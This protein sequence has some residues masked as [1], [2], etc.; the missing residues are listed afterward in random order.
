[1]TPRP[2]CMK[3]TFL[4]VKLFKNMQSLKLVQFPTNFDKICI[5]IENCVV[6]ITS[7]K[8]HDI[9]SQNDC[10]KIYEN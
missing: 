2:G 10:F 7:M 6:N 3:P 9:K 1:M 4:Q 8:F 5:Y